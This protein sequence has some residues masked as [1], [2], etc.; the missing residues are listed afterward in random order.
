MVNRCKQNIILPKRPVR[1]SPIPLVPSNQAGSGTSPTYRCVLLITPYFPR[2]CVDFPASHG[3]MSGR[4]PNLGPENLL[5]GCP[6]FPGSCQAR[7][8][9]L[10][11]AGGP[12]R[13]ST[14]E[15]LNSKEV[16]LGGKIIERFMVDFPSNFQI[17]WPGKQGKVTL[18]RWA[19]HILIPLM[20][21]LTCHGRSN[22]MIR[23]YGRI[24]KK[25]V[26]QK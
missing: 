25:A 14:W 13:F 8:K 5:P 3:K 18:G 4:S 11:A 23:I 17:S 19:S 10:A 16:S 20:G 26:Y 12:L 24:Q 1:F 2:K 21:G 15:I 9:H 7:S 22:A 6:R